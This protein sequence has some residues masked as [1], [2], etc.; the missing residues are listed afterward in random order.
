[1]C[2]AVAGTFART[3]G[4]GNPP[5]HFVS[6]ADFSGGMNS[7][8][9]VVAGLIERERSQQGQFVEIALL[10]GPML[11]LSDC[12]VEGE[13]VV[14]TFELDHDQRG[15]AS[16]NALYR[17]LDGWLV[18]AC[19]A[20]REWLAAHEA[21]GAQQRE[22]YS[23]ARGR[24]F[25]PQDDTAPLAQALLALNTSEALSRLAAHGVPCVEPQLVVPEMLLGSDL[26]RLGPITQYIHPR[27]GEV[28]EVGRPLRMR[29]WPEDLTPPAP[30]PGQHTRAV[31]GSFGF[32]GEEIERLHEAR[33]AVAA[34][35][36]ATPT[37]V[38]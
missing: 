10:G 13:E 3:G 8:P 1:M 22:S 21:L 33:V 7:A 19:Y 6:A 34:A 20:E 24:A 16:T 2:D 23:E 26:H 17:T 37:A 35:A 27:R 30:E 14:Q 25:A 12:Y 32:T 36:A 9:L 29:D 15:H 38:R 11:W 5:M 31:L 4:A 28:F 18:L